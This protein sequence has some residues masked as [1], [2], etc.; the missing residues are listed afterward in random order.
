MIGFFL[1]EE[2]WEDYEP[3]WPRGLAVPAGLWWRVEP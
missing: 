1:R 2:V 3:H